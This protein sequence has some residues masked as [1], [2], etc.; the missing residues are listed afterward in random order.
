[1]SPLLTPADDTAPPLL[2]VKPQLKAFAELQNFKPI[3]SPFKSPMSQE[4]RSARK[5][6]K[7]AV[8]EKPKP[9]KKIFVDYE[10]MIKDILSK[11]FT[12]PIANYVPEYTTKTLGMRKVLIRRYVLEC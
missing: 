7:D 9:L 3:N 10:A 4:K 2:S 6:R 5:G 11:P 12:V 8:E 1:V